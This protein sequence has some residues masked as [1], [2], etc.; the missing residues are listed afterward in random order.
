M[1][2]LAQKYSQRLREWRKNIPDF[3]QTNDQVSAPLVPIFQ[4]QRDVLNVNYWH[5][6]I[7]VLRPLLLRD[8]SQFQQGTTRARTNVQTSQIRASVTDCVAAAINLVKI[9]DEMFQTG[10]L[11]PSLWV[12]SSVCY[13]IA[14]L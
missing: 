2:A 13:L 6:V 4:R 3:L 9:V 10:D 11:F 14:S 12:G 8:F 1:Y 7:I 5:A